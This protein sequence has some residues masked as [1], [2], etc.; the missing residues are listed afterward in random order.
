M[1][2]IN[3][4]CFC[5]T[6][7]YQPTVYFLFGLFK[8]KYFSHANKFPTHYQIAVWLQLLS[9]IFLSE[10]RKLECYSLMQSTPSPDRDVTSKY[11][12]NH[13]QVPT[14]E[15]LTAGGKEL[16]MSLISKSRNFL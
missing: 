15:G 2:C 7:L 11:A 9:Q 14:I 16:E 5:L 12:E 4:G 1:D 13:T 10:M 8:S 6:G 3:T